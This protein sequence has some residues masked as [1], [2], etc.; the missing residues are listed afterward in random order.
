MFYR[1]ALVASVAVCVINL[2]LPTALHAQSLGELAAAQAKRRAAMAKESPAPAPDSESADAKGTAVTAKKVHSNQNLTADP[3]APAAT[4]SAA[5]TPAGTVPT[6]GNTA[7]TPDV[8]GK[9]GDAV[10]DEAYWKGRMRALQTKLEEDIVK[11][12]EAVEYMNS[13]AR[14]LQPSRVSLELTV[15]D[16]H[17]A[18][19]KVYQWTATIKN[20]KKAI[21]DLE[22]EARRL[23]VLPGWLRYP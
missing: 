22:E 23:G 2:A 12:N 13:L 15:P 19:E 8:K 20:D 18:E 3:T 21:A 4:P 1:C 10:K 11:G 14:G 9:P 16:L 17:A 5:S 6:T 7:S